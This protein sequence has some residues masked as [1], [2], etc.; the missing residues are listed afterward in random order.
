MSRL[1]LNIFLILILILFIAGTILVKRNFTQRNTEMLPGM[2]NSV[3]YNTFSPNKNFSDGKTLQAPVEET[4]V[5]GFVK[6][7]YTS[8]GEDAI[9]AGKEL[10]NPFSK[11]S[12]ELVEEGSKLFS[13]YCGP[14]HGVSGM[15]DG[16]I[17]QKGSP[18]PPSLF[19][20]KALSMKDGQMFHI[21]TYGQGNMPSL[22]SQVST[23]DRWKIILHI[24]SLQE[25][26]MNE[27]GSK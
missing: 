5:K 16:N 19:V 21:M 7:K 25:K 8:S 24:R 3:P 12:I 9:L 2:V 18:P 20:E 17:V 13:T 27:G 1:S 15:G 6:L 23:N 11:E 4:S 10:I 14:C 22:A 26:Q